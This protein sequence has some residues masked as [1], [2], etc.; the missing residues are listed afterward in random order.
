[1]PGAGYLKRDERRASTQ[2][3]ES[4]TTP[5]HDSNHAAARSASGWRL[6]ST[7]R[8]RL[9]IT[10]ASTSPASSRAATKLRSFS[11]NAQSLA[12]QRSSLS[13]HQPV[14]CGCPGGAAVLAFC[15]SPTVAPPIRERRRFQIDPSMLKPCSA[16]NVRT[17]PR[18]LD[19][20]SKT[21]RLVVAIGD[22]Q[23]VDLDGHGRVRGKRVLAEG[24]EDRLRADDDHLRSV[25]D[26]AGRADGGS[27]W[28]RRISWPS[29]ARPCAR[30]ATA[31]R[32][33]A[34]PP[35]SRWSLDPVRSRRGGAPAHRRD[36]SATSTGRDCAYAAGR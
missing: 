18:R 29:G 3:A 15:T 17:H 21:G 4:R 20:V 31:A 34:R 16:S 35:A 6:S 28:S 13:R 27:H 24:S 8:S 1:M 11:L 23:D 26:L 32:P 30:P 12:T 19:Q 5:F 36:R 33:S 9:R 7:L 25:D 22:R 2:H 10:P 14:N